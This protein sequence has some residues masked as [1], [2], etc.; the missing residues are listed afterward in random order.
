ML[1]YVCAKMSCSNSIKKK[2]KTIINFWW[3]FGSLHSVWAGIYNFVTFA[4]IMCK[5]CFLKYEC[6][7]P[8]LNWYYIH[9]YC[10]KI[11]ISTCLLFQSNRTVSKQYFILQSNWNFDMNTSPH[12]MTYCVPYFGVSFWHFEKILLS[13]LTF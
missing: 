1:S 4:R 10:R 3:V 12:N 13:N 2:K 7:L 5:L 9:Y 8:N 11:K 6:P